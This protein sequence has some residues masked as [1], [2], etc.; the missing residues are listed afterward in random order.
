QCEAVLPEC[1][2]KDVKE[3]EESLG[4][5]YKKQIWSKFIN[6]INDFD[7]IKDGDKIAIGVSGGKDSLL[8]VKLFQKLKK[9]KSRNFEFK[10][11]SLNPGFKDSDLTNFKSNLEKLNID[12]E[13]VDTNIWEIANAKAKDYPCFLCAKMRRGILY[14]RIEELG[15]NK[16]ALGH[17]FD[18]VVETTMMNMFYAGTLKTMTPIVPSTTGK[19]TLIRPMVYIKEDSIIDY[20]KKNGIL[21]MNCGCT[22]EAGKTSSKR[23]ET[24]ELL[25]ALEEKTPGIKQSI[26]NSM[27]NINL[28]YVFGYTRGNKNDKG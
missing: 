1:D 2:M 14:S 8:L 22:I 11:I 3:I 12:C 15:F 21:A 28:D 27:N 13:I 6:A 20:T 26:F 5:V 9:D 16:L 18:D 4:N 17:H 7:L 19:L 24:K 23:R 25:T 10:A